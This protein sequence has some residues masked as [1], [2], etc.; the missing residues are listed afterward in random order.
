MVEKKKGRAG[1]RELR[2]LREV[3]EM[4]EEVEEFR[5]EVNSQ[6][7]TNFKSLSKKVD[8][9]NRLMEEIQEMIREALERRESRV[10]GSNFP[11]KNKK[12]G[13]RWEKRE[14]YLTEK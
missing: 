4:R 9:T 3:R 11:K 12:K 10:G 5:E 2:E 13:K 14:V 6:L 8:G 1:R 7:K